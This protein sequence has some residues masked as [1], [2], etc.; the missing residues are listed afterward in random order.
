MI[1]DKKSLYDGFKRNGYFMP[2]AKDACMTI[3]FLIG[4][5][6]RRYF[7]PLSENI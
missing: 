2:K 7:L 5:R 1:T 6:E 3:K 4:V